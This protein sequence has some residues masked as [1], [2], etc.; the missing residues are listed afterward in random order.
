MLVNHAI[1]S[2]I[3]ANHQPL[4]HHTP[5]FSSCIFFFYYVL[6]AFKAR[7]LIFIL[8]A[9]YTMTDCASPAFE[10]N[11]KTLY[12]SRIRMYSSILLMAVF[13]LLNSRLAFNK[14][15]CQ[16]KQT[17]TFIVKQRKMCTLAVV[18]I[19]KNENKTISDFFY[20]FTFSYGGW[21]FV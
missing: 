11:T 16:T 5:S 17:F 21:V 13:C 10:P 7:Q 15:N 19:T 2:V 3:I 4:T 8:R 14:T 9:Q 20:Y 18:C 12:H 1:T 6:C